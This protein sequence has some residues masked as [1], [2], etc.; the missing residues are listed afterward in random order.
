[1]DIKDWY[2]LCNN[3]AVITDKDFS[4]KEN[5]TYLCCYMNENLLIT[6]SGSSK[7]SC[8]KVWEEECNRLMSLGKLNGKTPQSY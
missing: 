1:M 7:N 6:A 2:K 8:R 5:T 4:G 3:P